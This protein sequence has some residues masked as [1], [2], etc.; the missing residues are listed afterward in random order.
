VGEIL[1]EILEHTPFREEYRFICEGC[2]DVGF[3]CSF[4]SFCQ[5]S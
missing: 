3:Y 1:A 2:E 4:F 5:R